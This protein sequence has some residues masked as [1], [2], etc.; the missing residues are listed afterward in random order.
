[1][2][3]FNPELESGDFCG[4]ESGLGVP[5]FLN[6][7]VKSPTKMRTP[8]KLLTCM[9]KSSP[10]ESRTK[11]YEIKYDRN[12]FDDGFGSLLSSTDL[13]STPNTNIITSCLFLYPMTLHLHR[14]CYV[15]TAACKQLRA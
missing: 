11:H 15:F 10:L 1:M 13:C 4:L 14:H 5:I 12:I 2:S 8:Q 9:M 3:N 7:G 6:P